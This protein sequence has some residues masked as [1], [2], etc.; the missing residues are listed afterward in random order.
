MRDALKGVRVLRDADGL[1]VPRLWVADTEGVNVRVRVADR[2]PVPLK[3]AV[4]RALSER[5]GDAEGE[6]DGLRVEAVRLRGEAVAEAERGEAVR[7]RV[8]VTEGVRVALWVG[9]LWLGR[10]VGVWVGEA[11]GEPVGLSE[12]VMVVGVREPTVGDAVTVAVTRGRAEAVDVAEPVAEAERLRVREKVRVGAQDSDVVWEPLPDND[13]LRLTDAVLEKVAVGACVTV[14]VRDREPEALRVPLRPGDAVSE[15]E[16]VP[17]ALGL[18]EGLGLWDVVVV[19]TRD[20]VR[21]CETEG[22]GLKLLERVG[23]T[24]R[25]GLRERDG[26]VGEGVAEADGLGDAEGPEGDR[27]RERVVDRVT[28]GLWLSVRERVRVSVEDGEGV[29]VGD[30]VGERVGL[31]VR[32]LV[33]DGEGEQVGLRL[34]LRLHVN[35]TVAD[36]PP[37]SDAVRVALVALRESER[38][39]EGT[40]DPDGERDSDGCDAEGVAVHVPLVVRLTERLWLRLRLADG[41]GLGDPV[42][43]GGEAVGLQVRVKLRVMLRVGVRV[44]V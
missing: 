41:D 42:G 23:D 6:R 43:L 2:L 32:V 9:G 26:C 24:L 13:G 31:W 8:T 4:W 30:G 5:E 22:R 39:P 40:H 38:L 33:G 18:G 35:E 11:E 20:T 28:L 17:E 16:R 12:G 3:V 10:N 7:V 21:D 34:S 14:A 25:L 37:D 1:Q 29:C 44:V 36:A 27:V 15:P 19:G